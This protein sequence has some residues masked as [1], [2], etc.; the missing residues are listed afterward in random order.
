M[1]SASISQSW[2]QAGTDL[3]VQEQAAVRCVIERY[4]KDPSAV[5]DVYQEVSIKVLKRI[6]T[7]RER[8]AIRGW[9]FQVARNA[10][11]DYLRREDRRPRGSSLATVDQ[12]STGDM[13]RNPSERFLSSERIEAVHRAIEQLPAS[14]RDVISL[15][16]KEDLDHM[17]IAERLNISRQAVEV[18]LCR[19]RNALKDK[20]ADILGGDL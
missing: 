15:R 1:N 13:G 7:V 6:H 12:R 2:E 5:D 16:L 17:A 14:Q 10:S 18:R 3:L 11:L 8:K 4:I 20:L 19:G 9:L